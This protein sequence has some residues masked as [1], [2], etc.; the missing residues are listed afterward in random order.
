MNAYVMQLLR[1]WLM[2]DWGI[3]SKTLDTIQNIDIPLYNQRV[4]IE[5]YKTQ[6]AM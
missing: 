2:V 1:N 4:L 3:C 6:P 5:K